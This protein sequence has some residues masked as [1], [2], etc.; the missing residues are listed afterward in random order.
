MTDVVFRRAEFVYWSRRLVKEVVDQ[1]VATHTRWRPSFSASLPHSLSVSAS[2]DR[3]D[4]ANE[5]ALIRETT[6]YLKEVTGGIDDLWEWSEYVAVEIELEFELGVVQVHSGWE[7]TRNEDIAVMRSVLQTPEGGTTLVALFG[8]TAGRH[9][10]TSRWTAEDSR[11]ADGR[12]GGSTRHAGS[13]QH[14][15]N[16]ARG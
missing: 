15:R 3:I 9:A 12:C 4:S 1:E 2:K 14:R 13:A 8:S 11:E 7:G 10:T 6:K 5:F 16:S